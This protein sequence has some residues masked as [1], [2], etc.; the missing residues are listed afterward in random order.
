M[1]R[2][3]LAVILLVGGLTLW[4]LETAAKHMSPPVQY[5][6]TQPIGASILNIGII[7]PT[8]HVTT[9]SYRDQSLRR[10]FRKHHVVTRAELVGCPPF[11][12]RIFRRYDSEAL[13]AGVLLIGAAWLSGAGS[14]A[15]MA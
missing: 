4:G 7:G 3:V 1:W 9:P 11:W 14:R 10:C 2:K 13:V 12:I 6:A 8:V 5:Y 15:N